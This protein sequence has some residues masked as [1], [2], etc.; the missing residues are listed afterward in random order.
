MFI[1][2]LSRLQL[3]V[4]QLAIGGQLETAAATRNQFQVLDLLLE[5]GQQLGRQTDGLGFVV[6][7]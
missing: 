3:R 5:L 6:S 1:G 4:D 2:E 7:H